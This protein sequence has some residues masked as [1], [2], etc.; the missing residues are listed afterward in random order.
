M[1]FK[2]FL[3]GLILVATVLL[4]LSFSAPREASAMRCVLW[5]G[6][7][8]Q[9]TCLAY[10]PDYPPGG[11][12]CTGAPAP[13]EININTAADGSGYCV[14]IPAHFGW[15]ILNSTNGWYG[16]YYVKQIVDGNAIGP[17]SQ[18]CGHLGCPSLWAGYTYSY[19]NPPYSGNEPGWQSIYNQ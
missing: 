9:P 3:T 19:T 12:D 13:G 6:I 17:V 8:T 14:T 5:G 18:V 16:Y 15:W 1:N 11:R 2:K 4:G 7:L 10:R